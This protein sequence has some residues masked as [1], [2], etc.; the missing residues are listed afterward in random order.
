MD[1]RSKPEDGGDSGQFQLSKTSFG[2][3]MCSLAERKIGQLGK[4]GLTPFP[5][6]LS[7]LSNSY[8]VYESYHR[9]RIISMYILCR[10]GRLGRS[11][12]TSHICTCQDRP[13]VT[14]APLSSKNTCVSCVSS[15]PSILP[16]NW[17]VNSACH[18]W[19][20]EVYAY[21]VQTRHD[22]VIL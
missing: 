7:Y 21:M 2:G 15:K 8:G 14:L 11:V 18:R 3:H 5:G 4:L 10:L 6:V 12:V 17:P 1:E 16:M 19:C 20:N 13:L 9:G 22:P